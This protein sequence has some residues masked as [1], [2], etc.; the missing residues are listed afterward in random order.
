MD[1]TDIEQKLR[2]FVAAQVG[3]PEEKILP[4]TDIVDDFRIYGDDVWELLEEFGRQFNVNMGR[5]RWYH[6]SGL[7]GWFFRKQWWEKKTHIPIRL[8]DLVESVQRK[9]WSVMYPETEKEAEP[10]SAGDAETLAP[11]K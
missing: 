8:A 1:R 9:E 6:H 4:D 5:L 10:T 2:S 7:E 3:V 11:A